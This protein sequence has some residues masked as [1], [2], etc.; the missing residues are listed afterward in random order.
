MPPDN[1][2]TVILVVLDGWGIAPPGPGNAVELANTPNIDKLWYSFPHTQLLASGDAVGLPKG[3]A[4]NTE[5]GH[6]NLGAG[7][8]VYQDLERIN[9]S[10]ADGSFFQNKTLQDLINHANKFNSNIHLLGLIGAGGVHSN[11][12]H[13]F[14]LLKFFSS[15]NFRRVFIHLITDG[16]DSP[17]TS[18]KMYIDSLRKVIQQEKV[19]AIASIMGRYWAMDRD[20]RWD[21]TQKAYEALTEGKGHL[22]KTLEEAIQLSYSEGKTD[23][24]VEPSL[25]TNQDGSPI[26]L[27]KDNDVVVFFNFRVDRPRQLTAAFIVDDFSD[28]SLALD[29]DPYLEKYEKTHIAGKVASYQKVFAR[30]IKL[31]NLFFCTMTEYSKSL[32]ASGA[33]AIFP[34]E[35]VEMPLGRVISENSLRQLR[36]AESEKERFVTYYFNGQ[37]ENPFLGEERLIIPSPNVPTYDLKPEMSAYGVTEAVLNALKSQQYQFILVNYA[38]P[39]MVGHTGSIG[40]AVRACEVVDEC[41]GKIANYILSVGGYLLITADHGNVEEMINLKTGQVDTEHS[42]FPVPFI[43]VSKDFLGKTVTLESGILADIAPT[44]LYL[45]GINPPGEMMGKNLLKNI[46]T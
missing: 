45:L 4:G 3:E 11:I 16:R 23:E 18:S 33:R 26:T 1:K 8:I 28:S 34:P 21:R 17:P 24:F 40:P 27:I 42:T 25:I 9:M 20:R 31:N 44:V 5:T 7:R 22:V 46:L 38:N 19:G 10:I 43:A 35:I 6:L 39:D 12:E 15:K 37:R 30:K 29:F 41:V 36:V 13:L 14:A 2:K 32:T